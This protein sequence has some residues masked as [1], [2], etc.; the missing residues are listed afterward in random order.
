MVF[1]WKIVFIRSSVNFLWRR[2]YEIETGAGTN[3]Y[4]FFLRKKNQKTYKILY[5]FF[6]VWNKSLKV[7]WNNSILVSSSSTRPIQFA[8][9]FCNSQLLLFWIC[10]KRNIC[11]IDQYLH[12]FIS[13]GIIDS[14]KLSASISHDNRPRDGSN[15]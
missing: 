3:S 10:T 15:L 9:N 2:F 4:C 12:I 8:F 1:Y 13:C 11:I 7:T 6:S 14:Y 5:N